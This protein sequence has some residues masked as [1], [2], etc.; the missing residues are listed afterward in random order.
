MVYFITAEILKIWVGVFMNKFLI[1]YDVTQ[2]VL[3]ESLVD[4]SY[5]KIRREIKRTIFSQYKGK[6]ISRSVWVGEFNA[7]RESASV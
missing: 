7:E 3:D 6:E 5:D 1:A 2:E 4:N